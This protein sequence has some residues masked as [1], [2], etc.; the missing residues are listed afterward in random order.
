MSKVVVLGG[1]ILGTMH[2]YLALKA[3]HEVIQVERDL[4]PQSASV[5]NFGLIWVSGRLAGDE[6]HLA[7]RAREL[8]EEI[9]GQANIGFRGNGSLTIAA[10][11]AEFAVMQ[12]AVEMPDFELRGFEIVDSNEIKRL[13]PVL[14][15][16]FVGGIRCVKDGAVEP[17]L[18]LG[19]LREEMLKNE[20]YK[21]LNNFEAIDFHNDSFG[22]HLIS[23][24][25][26][27]VS[28]DFLVICPGIYNT[29]FL[30]DYMETKRIRKVYLQMA[31]TEPL[32][33]ILSHSVADADS[34]RYYPAF[35]DLPLENLPAQSKIAEEN[36]M[37]LLLCQRNDGSMTIGDTHIYKEPFP[38]E[39]YEEP[40]EHLSK[41]IEGFF[42]RPI[43]IRKR[44]SGVY[45]QSTTSDIY[46]RESISTNAVI[47]SGAGGRGNTLSPAI[48]EETL[49]SWQM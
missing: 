19:G 18:L 4:V 3:G 43:S 5:R 26:R 34:M 2:A 20:N 7:L 27:K 35:K 12:K 1:G 21:W 44:W 14:Q 40:Y 25:R 45:S 6:L 36:F 48:A 17:P 32:G 13:E 9:G 47:V 38:H 33:K 41:V 29:G 10:S 23:S 15:G 16:N 28:G 39:I 46:F 11:D 42:G 24:D 8:W 49:K 37:Q 30:R 31:A 22:N